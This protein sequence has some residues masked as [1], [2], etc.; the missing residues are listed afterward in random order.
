[1]RVATVNVLRFASVLVGAGLLLRTASAENVVSAPQQEPNLQPR[2]AARTRLVLPKPAFG[3]PAP[4][5]EARIEQLAAAPAKAKEPRVEIRPAPAKLAA[6]AP[7]KHKAVIAAEPAAAAE[8]PAPSFAAAPRPA[9]DAAPAMAFTKPGLAARSTAPALQP[10]SFA[11]APTP[12]T[13]KPAVATS[14]RASAPASASGRVSPAAVVAPMRAQPA[15]GLLAPVRIVSGTPVAR[16]PEAA[17]AATASAPAPRPATTAQPVQISLAPPVMR[18]GPRTT[19]LTTDVKVAMRRAASSWDYAEALPPELMGRAAV[20]PRQTAA[21]AVAAPAA[22]A[23]TAPGAAQL[24]AATNAAPAPAPAAATA[25]A[26]APGAPVA[27]AQVTSAPAPAKVVQ[28]EAAPRPLAL[29][30]RP[31][32]PAAV[33]APALRSAAVSAASRPERVADRRSQ[34]ALAVRD[35]EPARRAAA[36]AP[37]APAA[38]LRRNRKTDDA[39]AANIEVSLQDADLPAETTLAAASGG[40]GSGLSLRDRIPLPA[41]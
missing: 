1:M 4:A 21:A 12:I 26:Q 34:T 3:N 5:A 16:K 41:F 27:A 14:G 32:Q 31:A 38:D 11:V 40:D 37:L 24:A 29:L 19:E 2:D 39:G 15:A 6:S 10:V 30:D 8:L 13:A 36:P 35:A 22:R 28:G 20:A 17:I 25:S 33:K 7:V 18:P 9:D 23:V